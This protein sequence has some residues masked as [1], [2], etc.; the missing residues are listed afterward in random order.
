MGKHHLCI[1][2][3]LAC[4]AAMDQG[5][6]AFQDD[7]AN[8]ILFATDSSW[9]IAAESSPT[10]QGV[11]TLQH[12]GYPG[13]GTRYSAVEDYGDYLKEGPVFSMTPGLSDES[14]YPGSSGGGGSTG[15]PLVSVGTGAVQ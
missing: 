3:A 10:G 4:F 11:T 1:S 9:L 15:I 7:A 14:A 13:L 2:L 5:K 6:A 12:A 8:S